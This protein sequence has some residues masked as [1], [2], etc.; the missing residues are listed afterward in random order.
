[1]GLTL[2]LA[3]TGVA[4][5]G[6]GL[7]AAEAKPPSNDDPRSDMEGSFFS[8]LGIDSFAAKDLDRYLNPEA[9]G[10]NR[11]RYVAG[12]DFEYRITSKH[13]LDARQLWIYGE[14]VHGLRSSDVDCSSNPNAPVC[15]DFG[16]IASGE[17][18]IFI[19]RNSSSMEAFAGLRWE[20]HALKPNGSSPGML[21]LKLQAGFITA[22]GTGQD[23]IDLLHAGLGLLAVGGRFAGSYLEFGYGQSEFFVTHKKDRKKIDGFLT[24]KPGL[25]CHL[26]IN[27]FVQYTID[28]DFDPGADS[29]QTYIGFDYDLDY[30]FGTSDESKRKCPGDDARAQKKAA[31]AKAKAEKKGEGASGGQA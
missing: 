27:P 9:S 5:V 3:I 2:L 23:I 17:P 19:V 13:T 10:T 24:W 20:F 11:E 22:A 8:G 30:L 29:I 21:Y 18:A 15:Q 25:T 31:K 14:T 28:S 4:T 26:G 6:R 1:L 7:A 16:P 12:F